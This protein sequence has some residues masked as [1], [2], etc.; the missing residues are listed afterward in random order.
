MKIHSVATGEVLSTLE[1]SSSSSAAES[2]A[3]NIV[4]CAVLN[5]H[6]P[7]QLITGS[8]D[9]RIRVWDFLDAVLLKSINLSQPVFHIA[10]HENFRDTVT[11]SLQKTKNDQ[12]AEL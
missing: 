12:S 6:N 1:G 2:T 5:P 10:A 8:L 4:T 3:V 11:V 9:G 7:Y